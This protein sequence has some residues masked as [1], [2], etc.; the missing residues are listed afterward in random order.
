MT[1]TVG[2]EEGLC[3][4]YSMTKNYSCDFCG[5]VVEMQLPV[6]YEYMRVYPKY[7]ID[8]PWYPRER[9]AMRMVGEPAHF[10]QRAGRH[11]N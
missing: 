6:L 1:R 9:C 2:M 4:L 7:E 10:F 11:V 3:D 8:H 5:C